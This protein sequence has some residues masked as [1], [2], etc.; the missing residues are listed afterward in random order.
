MKLFLIVLGFFTLFSGDVKDYPVPN[1]K[2]N[3]LFYIQRTLNK[4]TIVYEANF[5]KNG[6]LNKEE[7]ILAYWMMYEEGGKIESLT[8]FEEKFAYGIK[9]TPIANSV[10]EYDIK[11]VSYKNIQLHLKQ[12]GPFKAQLFLIDKK[13]QANEI[14]HIFI[15]ANNAG[16]WTKVKF[17]EI[18]THEKDSQK[19]KKEIVEP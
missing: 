8:K 12:V 2:E 5:D 4:N 9:S 17:L 11:I 19:L 14:D 7:P 1:K 3:H 6:I 18:Y 15:H 10:N 16:L 13:E